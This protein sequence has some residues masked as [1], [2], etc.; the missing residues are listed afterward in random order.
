M[1]RDARFMKHGVFPKGHQ[2]K[3]KKKNKKNGKKTNNSKPNS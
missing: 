2:S 1:V 3:P